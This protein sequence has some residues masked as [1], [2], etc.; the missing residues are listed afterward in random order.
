MK[1]ERGNYC[2]LIGKDCIGLQCSWFTQVR[3][4]NPQT[5]EETDEWGCAVGWLPMLMIE[6]SQMQ[7]Q[8]SAAIESFRN[9]SVKST[10]QAQE[11]Y[12]AEL[13]LKALDKLQ[14]PRKT[15]NVTEE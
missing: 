12:K 15:L 5:G 2:P 7:R 9:E 11:I 10:L 4:M 6:N 14:E 1:L 13:K 8:T 3:G